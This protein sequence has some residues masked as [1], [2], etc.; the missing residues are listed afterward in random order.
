VL[1]DRNDL[2]A[3]GMN[4]RQVDRTAAGGLWLGMLVVCGTLGCL[5]VVLSCLCWFFAD[6]P[7][8]YHSRLI[9]VASVLTIGIAGPLFL[10]LSL[11]VQDLAKTNTKL[12]RLAEVDGLTDCL[13]R[14]AFAERV[15][16]HLV[17][18]S[19]SPHCKGALLV[20]DADYFKSINDKFGHEHGDEALTLIAER[21]RSLVRASDVV[22]RLGGEEF[23]VFLPDCSMQT[24]SIIAERIRAGINLLVFAPGGELRQLSVSIGGAVFSAPVEFAQ[25]FHLAD[26]RLY[27]A[28]QFGR[29][30]VE[31]G[32]VDT[33]FWHVP[34]PE[35]EAPPV[36]DAAQLPWPKPSLN[37]LLANLQL[38]SRRR[39]RDVG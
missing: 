38:R 33:R 37:G 11:V 16:R 13:N 5:L 10:H 9:I 18:A 28:K 27:E 19:Q 31:I 6:L 1:V 29:N 3:A 39:S 35:D 4:A 25:L 22:G 26:R 7:E 36:P 21:I 20:L 14:S 15:S 12:I 17:A 34:E 23:G 32:E 30:R 2:E 8:P 24:A